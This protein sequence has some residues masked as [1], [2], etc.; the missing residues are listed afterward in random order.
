MTDQSLEKL[1]RRLKLEPDNEELRRQIDQAVLRSGA[2]DILN[3]ERYDYLFNKFPVPRDCDCNGA[4]QRR[5]WCNTP[6]PFYTSETDN[7]FTGQKLAP[8]NVLFDIEGFEFIGRQPYDLDEELCVFDAWGADPYDGYYQDGNYHW[9]PRLVKE[10]WDRRD[11]LIALA[12]ELDELWGRGPEPGEKCVVPEAYGVHRQ[13]ISQD[14]E[15][16]LRVYCFFLK[17]RRL[18]RYSD[19]I[20]PLSVY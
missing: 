8:S 16:Y 6:G 10:W 5:T 7:C 19:A 14:L 13:F 15:D 17:H 2:A 11:E 9:S 3:L 12:T 20:P 1:R 4:F 18:P